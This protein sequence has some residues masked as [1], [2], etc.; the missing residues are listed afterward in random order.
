M[1]C[2]GDLGI[3]HPRPRGCTGGALRAHR[4]TALLAPAILRGMAVPTLAA[5][6]DTA[7]WRHAPC[8][9]RVRPVRPVLL[10]S[11]VAA[12]HGLWSG[13]RLLRPGAGTAGGVPTVEA[14]RHPCLPAHGRR[15]GA[16]PE[17]P[18]VGAHL[19]EA[20]SAL[21][22]VAMGRRDACAHQEDARGV[23]KKR[24]GPGQLSSVGFSLR[25][26]WAAVGRHGADR[27]Q[28]RDCSAT[29]LEVWSP[30]AGA[31]PDRARPG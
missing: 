30:P 8:H 23:G 4:R 16:A 12:R 21:A 6:R 1:R 19:A 2:R 11:T 25:L 10:G 7:R 27:Q 3:S 13:L 24:R 28:S 9:D 31:D 15:D 22:A 29:V 17:G 20:P 5:Q 26:L 14:Q 18:A